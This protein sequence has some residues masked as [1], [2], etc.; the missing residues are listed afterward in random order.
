MCSSR[1]GVGA[2]TDRAIQSA[3]KEEQ[4]DPEDTRNGFVDKSCGKS[5]L[6]DG[7]G[8]GGALRGVRCKRQ[9]RVRGGGVQG[10]SVE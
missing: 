8:G 10:W 2:G 7:S 9:L 4:R 1:A 6:T 3:G 5:T